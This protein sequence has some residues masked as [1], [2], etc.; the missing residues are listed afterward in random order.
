MTGGGTG[1]RFNR[2]RNRR[3]VE[4]CWRLA[5]E[6]ALKTPA[7]HIFSA[8]FLLFLAAIA[9]GLV[10]LC[11][12]FLAAAEK[13]VLQFLGSLTHKAALHQLAEKTRVRLGFH[14]NGTVFVLG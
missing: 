5:F 1:P 2:R 9:R 7:D 11:G 8:I 10:F 12:G 4:R 14:A 13:P 6:Q 3:L